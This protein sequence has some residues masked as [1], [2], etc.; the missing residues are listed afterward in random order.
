[1]AEQNMEEKRLFKVEEMTSSVE[2]RRGWKTILK[3]SSLSPA[4]YSPVTQQ[5]MT[6][7]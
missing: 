7:H 2:G 3:S 6:E 5:T 4:S 1:M